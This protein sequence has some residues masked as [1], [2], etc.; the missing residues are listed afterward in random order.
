ML[1]HQPYLGNGSSV[2]LQEARV[3]GFL[4]LKIMVICDISTISVS[5]NVLL[6]EGM[7]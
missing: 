3:V 1:H 7:F 6:K 4:F 5:V 2:Q